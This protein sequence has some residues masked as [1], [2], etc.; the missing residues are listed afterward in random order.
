M[1]QYWQQLLGGKEKTEIALLTALIPTIPF[2]LPGVAGLVFSVI[3]GLPFSAGQQ[4]QSMAGTV[5]IN[6]ALVWVLAAGFGYGRERILGWIGLSPQAIEP[7]LLL[8][9][10]GPYV[11][12][13]IGFAGK[14]I[15]RLKAIFEGTHY[16]GWAF[17]IALAGILVMVLT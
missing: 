1:V 14:S 15:L 9:W 6:L 10:T 5:A 8:S 13:G 12:A 11:E 7:I 4:A 3:T 16:L 17:L 2:L